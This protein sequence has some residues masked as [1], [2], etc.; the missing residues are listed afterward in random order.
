MFVYQSIFTGIPVFSCLQFSH[1][2][3]SLEWN[4]IFINGL[5]EKMLEVPDI[6][7]PPVLS[8]WIHEGLQ[9]FL[10]EPKVFACLHAKNLSC[11]TFQIM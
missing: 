9:P 5:W 8:Q 7:S 10:V 4:M 6:D 11:E 1:V 3:L 2:P